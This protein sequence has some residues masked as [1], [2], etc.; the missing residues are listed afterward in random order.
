MHIIFFNA[1]GDFNIVFVIA[2]APNAVHVIEP[3][4]ANI[5]INKGSP[6]VKQKVA[7]AGAVVIPMAAGTAGGSADGAGVL[8]C[9][10]KIL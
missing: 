3:G 4:I 8:Y 9:L 5:D 10:N 2:A 7:K 6:D 1:F